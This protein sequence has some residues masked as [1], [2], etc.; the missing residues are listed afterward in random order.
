MP[1]DMSRYPPEWESISLRIRA[2]SGGRCECTGECGTHEGHAKKTRR[3]NARNYKPHPL[4]GSKVIF[5]VAHLG[6]ENID[7]TPGD[8]HN[9]LDCRDENLKAM[10]Q[11]C[12]LLFDLDEHIE[13]RKETM[14]QRFIEKGNRYLPGF[15]VEPVNR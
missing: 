11:R 13:N 9:K 7:G 8:K 14:R 5:T 4:T 10:C 1:V 15:E 2:R 12:H 3:C 6:V